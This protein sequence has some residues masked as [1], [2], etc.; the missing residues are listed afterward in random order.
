[1]H[2]DKESAVRQAAEIGRLVQEMEKE[3]Q[4]VGGWVGNVFVDASWEAHVM[5]ARSPEKFMD[6]SGAKESV[7]EKTKCAE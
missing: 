2:Q 5:K 1:M 6:G 7:E 3:K 4:R